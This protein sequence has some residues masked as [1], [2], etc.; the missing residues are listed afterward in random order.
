[1]LGDNSP[2]VYHISPHLVNRGT[3]AFFKDYLFKAIYNPNSLGRQRF[4]LPPEEKED[5]FT[6]QSSKYNV[7]LHDTFCTGVLAVHYKTFGFP[8][9]EVS[10]LEQRFALSVSP[11]PP[12]VT[13]WELGLGET[14][15]K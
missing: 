14:E 2:W 5:S 4:Y 8:K 3:E 13:V 12:C 9:P 7:S 15:R 10:L 11:G 1:M 6:S